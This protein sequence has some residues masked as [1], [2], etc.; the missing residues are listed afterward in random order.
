MNSMWKAIFAGLLLGAGVFTVNARAQAVPDAPD[1]ARMLAYSSSSSGWN[2]FAGEDIDGRSV[3]SAPNGGVRT[4]A[5]QFGGGGGN[6]RY[7]HNDANIGWSRFAIEAG[8]GFTAPI[9]NAA[10]GGFTTLLGG[11]GNPYGTITWGGNFLV[12][13]GYNFSKR[14]GLLGEFSYN[15]NKIPGRTLSAAYAQI[16]NNPQ[17]PGLL[18]QNGVTSIGGN[19]HTYGVTA[20]PIFYYY[21]SSKGKFG[22]YVIGG[23]GFYHKST[24][25]TAPVQAID[26][27]FGTVYTVNQ[28]FSSYSDNALGGNLGTGFYF[29]P[30]GEYSSAKIFAETRYHF[31]NTPAESA[32][33]LTAGNVHTGTEE[34]LPVS[35]GIRF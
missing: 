14:F 29:K 30:F 20:E 8:G 27:Y 1:A 32:A 10:S 5:P 19:V 18:S 22:G 28:T 34:L 11:P 9:G 4:L 16:D 7:H 2:P 31:V 33:D 3:G 35:I 13:G 17:Q 25:F 23:G 26:P 24:N 6:G 12:G 21:N 15:A